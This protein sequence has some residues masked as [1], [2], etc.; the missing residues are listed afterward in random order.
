MTAEP[1]SEGPTEAPSV[2]VEIENLGGIDRLEQRIEPGVTVLSGQNATNRTSFLRALATGLGGTEARTKTDSDGES[3]VRLTVGETTYER[4]VADTGETTGDGYVDSETAREVRPFAWLLTDNE[5]RQ[6]L[7]SG[8]DLRELAMRPV[9]TDAIDRREAELLERRREVNAE[10]EELEGKADRLPALESDIRSLKD[11]IEALEAELEEKREELETADRDVATAEQEQSERQRAL[12]ERKD[13]AAEVSRLESTV[14][15]KA[16]AIDA[17]EAQLAETEDELAAA[18]DELEALDIDPETVESEIRTL[19]SER[20]E[21]T[22]VKNALDTIISFNADLLNRDQNSELWALLDPGSEAGEL[23]DQLLDDGDQRLDCWTC[24]A[25]TEVS[26]IESRLEW[27]KDQRESIKSREN[28]IDSRVRSLREEKSRYEDAA[29]EVERLSGEVARLER[30]LESRR[31]ERES[32]AAELET[33]RERLAEA[34][35]ALDEL[36]ADGDDVLSLSRAVSD[37]EVD[38]RNAREELAAKRERRDELDSALEAR[39]ELREEI[40]GLN[41]KLTEVRTEIERREEAVVE[42]FNEQIA[43]LI[44]LLDYGNIAR[45][46]L[47]RHVGETG[48][49]SDADTEFRLHIVREHDDGVATEDRVE[50]LSESEREI[51]AITFALAGY[52]AHDIHETMPFVLFDSVEMIDGERLNRLFEYF[53]G[54]TEYIVAALL[55]EDARAVEGEYANEVGFGRTTP[56]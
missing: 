13:A 53:H 24:G 8:A 25:E 3:Y 34:E 43:D 9:D 55:E 27:L 17:L 1:L 39:T 56:E 20:S 51:I 38:L 30:K 26:G 35:A 45:V 31:A 19:E 4:R 44:D 48:G 7:R 49:K 23:T 2:D 54:R 10:L 46:R 21:I 33:A 28:D 11:E 32:K 29:D 50:N 6:A 36:E 41:E 42:T 47:T 16:S 18:E 5:T 12:D 22:D 14:E 37:L 40:E 15:T 52:F